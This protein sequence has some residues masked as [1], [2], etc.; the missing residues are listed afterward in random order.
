M[1]AAG[2]RRR[3][4]RRPSWPAAV[5]GLGRRPPGAGVP[6]PDRRR[7]RG[8]GRRT[9]RSMAI[10]AFSGA[11]ALKPRLDARPPEAR[12]HLPPARRA[13]ARRCAT[14]AQAAAL[15]PT[16]PRPIELLGDVNAAMGRYERAAEH[17][18]AFIALDDRAPRV[19]YKLALAHYRNGQAGAGDRAAAPGASRSTTR[20]A[21][22]HYLLGLCL[23]DRRRDRRGAARAARAPSSSNPTFA[24]AREELADLYAATRPRPRRA[25][26]SSKRW[27]RSSRRGRSGSSASASPTRGSGA[28][29]RP[30]LTLG[31]AAERYP[32]RRRR[33]T[34]R[35][36]GSGSRR[37]EAQRRPRGARQGAR[38][39]AAR[40]GAPPTRRARR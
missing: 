30:S 38:G 19:L 33:S 10:E 29:R 36:A 2:G 8:A 26:S 34:R 9:R 1:R 14:C 4:R 13:D 12:R 24:A 17:Y 35:S 23:R 15:D 11:L 40:R 22:A 28:P 3:A 20:F 21:E 18:R 6:A 7:R 5:L 37:A 27:R 25:S 31:R 32:G 39:A 16:A